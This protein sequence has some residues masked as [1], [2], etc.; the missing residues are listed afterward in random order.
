M[1]IHLLYS[2]HSIHYSSLGARLAELIAPGKYHF[3]QDQEQLFEKTLNERPDIVADIRQR[4]ALFLQMDHHLKQTLI[5]T[6][7]DQQ[8]PLA[9]TRYIDNAVGI[10]ENLP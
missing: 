6:Q 9:L 8:G 2:C 3:F 5:C 7:Q 1:G 10:E 4:D